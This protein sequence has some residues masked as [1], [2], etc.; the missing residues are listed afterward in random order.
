MFNGGKTE[1]QAIASHNRNEDMGKFQ[2]GGTAMMVYGN[3]IQQFD[4]EGSGQDNLGLGRWTYMKFSGN[5]NIIAQV[6]CKYSPCANKQKDLGTVYQQHR[7]HLINKLNEDT[8][9]RLRFGE[10]LLR[11]MK[12]WRRKGEWLIFCVNANKNIYIGEL[13]QQLMDLHGLGMKEVVGEFTARKPGAT[14]F[15][16]SVPIDAIW[17]TSDVTV[18]NACVMSVGY[19]VEDHCLFVVDFATTLLVGTGCM[20]KIIQPALHCLN[21]RIKGCAQWYNKALKRNT[22]RHCLLERMVNAASSNKSN[23]VISKQLNKL[24]KE[25]EEYMKNAEKKCRR[26]K[27]RR[28]PFSPEVLLWIRQSQVYISLY[29]LLGVRAY[30]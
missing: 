6:I 20:Q 12:Q 25:G 7:Q 1:L 22:L 29:K 17:A 3:L 14:Y 30:P 5:D 11:K 27:L 19:G 18:A 13:G 8:C 4:P 24:D 2:E 21:T 16:G 23:E 9:P 28:I 10:D 15:Q 26:L